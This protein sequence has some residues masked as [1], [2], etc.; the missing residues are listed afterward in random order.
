[1][2]KHGLDSALLLG[3]AVAC[4]F[5]YLAVSKVKAVHCLSCSST[6]TSISSRNTKTSGSCSSKK[7]PGVLLA[8]KTPGV[9]LAVNRIMVVLWGGLIEAHRLYMN[10]GSPYRLQYFVP[11]KSYW[12]CH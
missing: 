11:I 3:T 6:K 1:M 4:A 8:V 7:T 10:F 12:S 9:L 2:P 5:L